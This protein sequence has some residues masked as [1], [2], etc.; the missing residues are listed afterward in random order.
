MITSTFNIQKLIAFENTFDRFFE[1]IHEE[2][3]IRG[4]IV[5]QDCS[6]LIANLLKYNVSNQ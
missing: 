5:V 1:I 4:S 2:G 6:S 3:D